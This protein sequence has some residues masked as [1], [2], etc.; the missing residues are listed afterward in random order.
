L[1]YVKV[2]IVLS[3]T[4]ALAVLRRMGRSES[5]PLL[6]AQQLPAC[7][8]ALLSTTLLEAITLQ[9]D[10]LIIPLHAYAA[11]AVAAF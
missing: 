11:L 5:A 6:A 10:N 1:H 9:I 3:S 7:I 2:S 4:A 8:A